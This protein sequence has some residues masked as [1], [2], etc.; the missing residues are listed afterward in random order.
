[1]PQNQTP[2]G[3]SFEYAMINSIF[4]TLNETQPVLIQNTPAYKV[5]KDFYEGLTD[6]KKIK[7]DKAANAAVKIISRLE[8]QLTNPLNNVPLY[9][10]I[11]EDI[12]GQKGDVRDIL[13]I[14]SQNNWEI[15]I[16]CKHNHSAVKH[17]RLSQTIDFGHEWLNMNC[18]D[19]Y[20]NEITPIFDELR[21]LKESN[22]LWRELG[23]QKEERTYIPLLRAFINEL[24]RLNEANPDVPSMLIKYLLGRN[25]FYKVISMEQRKLTKIQVFSMYGTLNKIAGTIHP[26]IR[27]GNLPLPT[28]IYDISFKP[29]SSNTIL[30]ACD[31]GW[32]IRMRIH[33][34]SSKVEPSLKFDVQLE[35]VPP[36]LY[37]HFEPWDN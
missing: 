29:D 9:L 13:T 28:R 19:T 7:M 31:R 26:Q 34:A 20:F 30:V 4:N 6:A 11:Q 1:M 35:G 21:V 24:K 32:S 16:S 23:K 17:S 8:P 22:T 3:K 15:G 12:E 36:E 25:D 27:I 18:S 33:N 14:R 2:L 5:A 10:M 37:T